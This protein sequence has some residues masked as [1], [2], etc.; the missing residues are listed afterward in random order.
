MRAIGNI[1]N[2]INESDMTI[3]VI[4]LSTTLNNNTNSSITNYTKII[5]KSDWYNNL[6]ASGM[7]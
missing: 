3:M 7:M 2:N 6:I 1:N 4:Q 5:I